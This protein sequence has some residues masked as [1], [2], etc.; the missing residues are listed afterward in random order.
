VHP[1]V[2]ALCVLACQVL[3]EEI[4]SV[5]VFRATWAAGV[6]ADDAAWAANAG[7]EEAALIAE[8]HRGMATMGVYAAGCPLIGE[9]PSDFCGE[10]ADWAFRVSA[11]YAAAAVRIVVG[12]TPLQLGSTILGYFLGWLRFVLHRLA[13]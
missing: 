6:G 1:V 2:G 7:A 10:G 4:T 13:P 3:M 9:S 8:L 5:C 11:P 12:Y